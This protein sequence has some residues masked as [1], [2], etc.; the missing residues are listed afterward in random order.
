MHRLS[1]NEPVMLLEGSV[2]L[3]VAIELISY[4]A[5]LGYVR[6]EQLAIKSYSFMYL[7]MC[8]TVNSNVVLW[9]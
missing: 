5:L 7:C 6:H 4:G 1:K 8:C 2:L 3:S 9:I